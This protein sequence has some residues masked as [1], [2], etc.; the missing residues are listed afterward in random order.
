VGFIDSIVVKSVDIGEFAKSFAVIGAAAGSFT[1]RQKLFIVVGDVNGMTSNSSG[2]NSFDVT[3]SSLFSNTKCW[4]DGIE[5]FNTRNCFRSI[6]PFTI[7][8]S[9]IGEWSHE[10]EEVPC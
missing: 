8:P 6:A 5:Q 7:C 1:R 10:Q 2:S 9:S 4:F 3:F